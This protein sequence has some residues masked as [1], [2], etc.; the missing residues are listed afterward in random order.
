[1]KIL[2]L[3]N[4]VLPQFAEYLGIPTNH[5]GGWMVALS[6]KLASD[7]ALTVCFPYPNEI[8]DT[9]G[10]VKYY[11]FA[12]K[13][14]KG[15][16]NPMIDA[17]K[18]IIGLERPD[19]IHIWG[20]EHLHSFAMT[21]AAKQLGEQGK[22]LI[23]IQGLTS[24]LKYHFMAGLPCKVQNGGT[25]RDFVRHDTLK[26][27]QRKMRKNGEYEIKAIQ[28]VSHVIGRTRWDDSCTRAIN[29]SVQYHF[30][31]EI[32]R[33]SFYHGEW[34][35]DRCQRHTVFVSQAQL[36]LKGF[37]FVVEA[38]GMLMKKYPDLKIFVAGGRN[39]IAKTWKSTA[40]QSYL[41][42]LA[43]ETGTLDAIA[44]VG[45]LNELQMREQ[46]LRAHV[47]VSA[48]SIENSP[49][50]V[51][52]AMILG[53]PIVASNVGGTCDMLVDQE[54]GF[55]YQFDAPYMLAGYIDALFSDDTLARKMATAAR[56]HAMNTHDMETNYHSL[57]NI[58]KD[59]DAF[60]H[61][62]T[63]RDNPT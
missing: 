62:E 51:G 35:M 16:V 39:P 61:S 40:Y 8:E 37:H 5:S 2:W 30:N 7:H 42:G 53:M 58:Y 59:I 50:S 27:Q 36:P 23:S 34:S 63:E 56:R 31:N 41:Y 12:E 19:I 44:Y 25:V 29:P 48:S 1:M 28:N 11:G 60:C 15:F 49:N 32:L 9:V 45:N 57:L 18:R 20:T 22:V 46:F 21:E 43:K 24:V 4:I 26:T 3:V 54:E 55:L 13:D 52:E 14:Q 6:K 10:N 38:A 17:F 47:F 33:E